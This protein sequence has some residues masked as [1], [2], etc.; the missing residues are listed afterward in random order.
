MDQP[1]KTLRPKHLTQTAVR[2]E[3]QLLERL[4]NYC[5]NHRLKPKRNSVIEA[6]IKE[7]LD[8]EENAAPTR[9]RA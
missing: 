5:D 6:A 4:N 1:D 2:I 8:S 3:P 9:R 7:F